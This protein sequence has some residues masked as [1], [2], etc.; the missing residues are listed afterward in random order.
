MYSREQ[1]SLLFTL[2]EK[3]EDSAIRSNIVIAVGDMAL[4]FPNLVEPWTANIYAR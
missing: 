4:R 2:L 1:L 3:S